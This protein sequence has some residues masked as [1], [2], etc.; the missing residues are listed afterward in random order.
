[1]S[2]NVGRERDGKQL[3]HNRKGMDSFIPALEEVS[4]VVGEKCLHSSL[5]DLHH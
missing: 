2:L 4:A 5:F 3:S 1:M